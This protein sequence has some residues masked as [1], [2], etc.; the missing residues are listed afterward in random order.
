[1]TEEE[2]EVRNRFTPPHSQ[3]ISEF[4]REFK[5]FIVQL[6]LDNTIDPDRKQILEYNF[7]RDNVHK[8]FL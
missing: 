7:I 2:K 8:L 1:M 6:A 4:A 3:G 5:V